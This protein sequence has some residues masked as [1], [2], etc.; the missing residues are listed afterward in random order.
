MVTT[1]TVVQFIQGWVLKPFILDP[2]EKKSFIYH[3]D[4]IAW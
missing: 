1:D 2:Q 3:H 4:F